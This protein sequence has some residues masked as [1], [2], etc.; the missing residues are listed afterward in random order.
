MRKFLLVLSLIALVF[1]EGCNGCLEEERKGL[2]ELKKAFVNEYSNDS[3]LPS[4]WKNIHDPES[5]TTDCCSWER[6]TCNSTTGHVI[7]LFLQELKL[8][9]AT[10]GNWNQISL[11]QSFEQLGILNLSSNYLP[12]WNT[13]AGEGI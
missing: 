6:V 5:T 11:F 2:L 12:D 8:G 1:L 9:E 4:S 10:S 13:T 7:E 3:L